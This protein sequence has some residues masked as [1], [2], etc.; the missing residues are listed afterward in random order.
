MEIALPYYTFKNLET[1]S[2]HTI[3]IFTI[4]TTGPVT[5]LKKLEIIVGNI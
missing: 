4:G 2:E 5:K 1:H 3:K